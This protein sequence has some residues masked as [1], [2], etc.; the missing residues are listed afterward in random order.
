MTTDDIAADQR[1]M[2]G[3]FLI[4]AAVFLAHDRQIVRRYDLHLEPVV[5]QIRGVPL[6]AIALRVLVEVHVAPIGR[7]FSA[8]RNNAGSPSDQGGSAGP[9]DKNRQHRSAAQLVFRDLHDLP[10]SPAIRWHTD[11]RFAVSPFF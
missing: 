11:Y 7:G 10:P 2:A 8:Q 5:V 9:A 1:D 6:T 3:L 4:G